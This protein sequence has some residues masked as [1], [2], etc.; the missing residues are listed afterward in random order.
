MHARALFFDEPVP[1]ARATEIQLQ[2]LEARIA[3][4]IPDACLFLEHLPVVTLGNR[5]RD[6]HLLFTE[7]QLAEKGIELAHAS[8]GGDVTFHG[9]GQLVLYPIFKIGDH[10]EDSHGHLCNLEEIAIRT[11]AR[12]GVTAYR[13]EGKNG[14]WHDSGKIA[15]IGF[16]LK[17]W[18]TYHGMSFN[19]EPDLEGFQTI[20]PCGLQGEP[21]S[22]L[23]QILGE[24]CPPLV[25]VRDA[26]KE[27]VESV[28]G[29]TM[30]VV[31]ADDAL[32]AFF[33]DSYSLSSSSS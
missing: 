21:V 28:T 30:D 26:M 22:S 2:L 13:R 20:V 32:K 3:D 23:K 27:E 14:A 10:Q 33:G 8:R 4:E 7:E 25:E 31:G 6:Q 11:A 16:R 18:V 29:R 24:D 5:G 19:V 12:F 15:A 9:P 1:Y 17:R